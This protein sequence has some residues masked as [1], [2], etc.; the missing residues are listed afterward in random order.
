MSGNINFDDG[1]SGKATG[2]F[3]V[4]KISDDEVRIT[5]GFK[6]YDEKGKSEGSSWSGIIIRRTSS[7]VSMEFSD[8][9]DGEEEWEDKCPVAGTLTKTSSG[10]DMPVEWQKART[11]VF[12]R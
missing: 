1:A 12:S 7:D 10:S 3:E 8:D 5:A 9:D 4:L 6:W 2:K 11:R